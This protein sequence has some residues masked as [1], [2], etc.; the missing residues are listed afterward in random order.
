[1]RLT[2]KAVIQTIEDSPDTHF[3]VWHKRECPIALTLKRFYPGR[4]VV[5]WPEV[6]YL[7]G[8]KHPI[9]PALQKR[10]TPLVEQWVFLCTPKAE[11]LRVLKGR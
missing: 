10:I 2:L 4:S 5:V 8:A 1:M 11:L 6:Y 9:P 3:E 7:D